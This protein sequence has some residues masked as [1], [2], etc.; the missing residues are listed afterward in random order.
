MIC[1]LPDWGP[2]EFA[3]RSQRRTD[4]IDIPEPITS[5]DNLLAGKVPGLTVLQSSGMAGSGSQIRL[6]GN[7]SVALSNQPLIYVDGI[8][9]RS[10]AYP[11]NAPPSGNVLRGA[12][13]VPS[14][15]NDIDP[16]D[17]ERVEIVRGPAATTLYGT[18]AATV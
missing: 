17:I 13:D 8:R 12:N 2:V 4:A 16:A 18:E 9:I 1:R 7:A 5:I 15:L 3:K 10:D 11:R 6:R 14:P